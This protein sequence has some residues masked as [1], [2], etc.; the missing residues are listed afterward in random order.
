M[1]WQTGQYRQSSDP[2]AMCSLIECSVSDI[3]DAAPAADPT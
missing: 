1:S 3:A 2:V